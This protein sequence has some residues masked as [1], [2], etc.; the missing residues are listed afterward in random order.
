MLPLTEQTNN[1]NP[2]KQK[3]GS[4]RSSNNNN[5]GNNRMKCVLFAWKGKPLFAHTFISCSLSFSLLRRTCT[6][7]QQLK[8]R[9]K[10]EFVVGKF[11]GCTST[12]WMWMMEIDIRNIYIYGR[13]DW[14]FYCRAR[15]MNIRSTRYSL[16]KKCT[17]SLWLLLLF[18]SLSPVFIIII[19]INFFFLC[20][21]CS[22]YSVCVFMPNAKSSKVHRVIL[23]P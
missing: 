18:H 20:F 5:R 9:A 7:F 12:N 3:R 4:G 21:L 23:P 10:N 16:L 8:V 6:H 13:C 11:D 19:I 2:K 1:R 14:I 22:I 15:T 17:R